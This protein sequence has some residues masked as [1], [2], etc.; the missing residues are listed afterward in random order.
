[1]S[2]LSQVELVPTVEPRINIVL[3][4]ATLGIIKQV[5][6]NTNQSVSRVCA[7]FIKK[8]IDNDE[9]A[10]YVKMLEQIG[11]IDNKPKINSQE[12]HRRLDELQD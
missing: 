7:D 5:A 2:H 9:D 4:H 8:Q 10:Y 12:M 1:M 6:Q 3:D 11:D